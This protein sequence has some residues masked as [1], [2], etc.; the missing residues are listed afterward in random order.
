VQSFFFSPKEPL[1]GWVLGAGPVVL[2]PTGT[3]PSLR[4]EQFGLGPTAVALRQ[5]HGWTYGMLANQIWGVTESD[6]HP[7]VNSTFLQ[8]FISHTF[9]TATTIALNTESTYNWTERQWTVPLNLMVNQIVKIGGMPVQFFVG[10][11]YYAVAPSGGPEW[12]LR[13]GFTLLFP[14]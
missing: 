12:G 5:D 9:H 11:R 6:D 8:P 7:D 4:S 2:W 10:G 3:D 1:K 14:K 13:F